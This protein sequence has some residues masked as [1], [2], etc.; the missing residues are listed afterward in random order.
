MHL[1]NAKVLATVETRGRW[2]L[3]SVTVANS[4]KIIFGQMAAQVPEIIDHPSF[5]STNLI[6]Q[7]PFELV[8]R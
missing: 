4:P 8:R 2:L 3:R 5:I 6:I 7:L 1:R